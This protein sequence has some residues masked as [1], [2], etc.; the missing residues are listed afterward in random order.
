MLRGHVVTARYLRYACP[1]DQ[2]LSN[3]PA[4]LF[5]SPPP[6]T[7]N[8]ITNLNTPAAARDTYAFDY[9]FDHM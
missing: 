8:T 9:M 5:I 1:R 2:R 7:P 6:A 3:D 4:F